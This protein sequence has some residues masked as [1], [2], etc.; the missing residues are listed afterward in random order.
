MD[1]GA[2]NLGFGVIVQQTQCFHKNTT[3]HKIDQTWFLT[4]QEFPICTNKERGLGW[5]ERMWPIFLL[6][7]GVYP[8][9]RSHTSSDSSVEPA[10]WIILTSLLSWRVG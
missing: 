3:S 10:R 2:S 4:F 6:N 7:T 9:L 5:I 8:P 1:T